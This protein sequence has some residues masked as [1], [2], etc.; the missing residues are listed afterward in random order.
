VVSDAVVGGWW[1][2]AVDVTWVRFSQ[3]GELPEGQVEQTQQGMESY[4]DSLGE[5]LDD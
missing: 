4:F 1:T 3:F 5:Y 2:V